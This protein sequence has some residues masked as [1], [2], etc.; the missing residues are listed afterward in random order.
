VLDELFNYPNP[1]VFNTYP[2]TFVLTHN[3]AN[4]ELDITLKLY[5]LNG[6]LVRTVE[7]KMTP[8][9]YRTEIFGW[10]GSDEGAYPVAKG[11]YLYR[12]TVVDER[13]DSASLDGKLIMID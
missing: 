8:T 6:Q 3:R 5:N 7:R 10:N 13:G 11:V 2:T 12:V 1:F 4:E 9:G